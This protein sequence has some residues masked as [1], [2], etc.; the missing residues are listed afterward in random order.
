MEPRYNEGPRDWQNRFTETS[1]II[2]RFSSIYFTI[3]GVKKIVRYKE[4]FL[5]WRFVISRFYCTWNPVITA[6]NPEYKK[7]WITYIVG[8]VFAVAI[9]IGDTNSDGSIASEN[10]STNLF[11]S[12]F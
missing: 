7:S 4:D 6:W 11:N 1:L 12:F 8:R 2:S 10:A 3:T 9:R 5:I